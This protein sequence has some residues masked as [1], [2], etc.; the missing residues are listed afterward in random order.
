[1]SRF[2][3]LGVTALVGVVGCSLFTDL[4]GLH[5]PPG[6]EDPIDT[7]IE[8]QLDAGDA[9]DAGDGSSGPTTEDPTP[10]DAAPPRCNVAEHDLCADFDEG[11]GKGWSV[12]LGEVDVDSTMSTSPPNSARASLSP[13][14]TEP[15]LLVKLVAAKNPRAATCE[16][17][18]QRHL[19]GW[20][21]TIS[22]FG[23]HVGLESTGEYV[24]IRLGATE[25]QRSLGIET[26]TS[27]EHNN[28]GPT[29]LPGTWVRIRA[30]IDLTASR[31]EVQFDDAPASTFDVPPI[32]RAKA[33]TAGF[34]FGI[35]SD[36]TV[37]SL[38]SVAYDDIV[39]DI[40][41]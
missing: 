23:M 37:S 8:R 7:P 3:R 2:F 34:W 35:D 38:T 36:A 31:A 16:F 32:D 33:T 6:H 10:H 26:D 13:D 39:C 15:P 17:S 21:E 14:A 22:F 20:A 28:L 40:E 27:F 19:T 4:S 29:S 41:E 12:I 9:G 18:F 1:M 5:D 24:T 30:R 25:T 11:L